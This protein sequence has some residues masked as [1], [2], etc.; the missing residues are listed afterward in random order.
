MPLEEIT[1]EEYIALNQRG[2]FEFEGIITNEIDGIPRRFYAH[3]KNVIVDGV[4]VAIHAEEDNE[5]SMFCTAPENVKRYTVVINNYDNPDFGIS[6]AIPLTEAMTREKIMQEFEGIVDKVKERADSDYFEKKY[7]HLTNV[8]WANEPDGTIKY[9][10]SMLG[11][12]AVMWAYTDMVLLWKGL[13]KF[14]KDDFPK[15]AV[16]AATE[17]QAK[18]AVYWGATWHQRWTGMQDK[19]Q[20]YNLGALRKAG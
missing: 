14:Y 10:E 17:E 5:E 6:F 18:N 4:R 16:R 3:I 19:R 12:R 9:A 20:A 11:D 1:H 13:S 2:N 7:G 8:M 15:V